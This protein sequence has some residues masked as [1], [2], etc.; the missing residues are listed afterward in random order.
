MRRWLIAIWRESRRIRFRFIFTRMRFSRNPASC[1]KR[2]EA[3]KDSAGRRSTEPRRRWNTLKSRGWAT[4]LQRFTSSLP[5]T[6]T[7]TTEPCSRS[8]CRKLWLPA[9]RSNSRCSSTTSWAKYL[10]ARDTRTTSSWEPSGSPR[11]GCGGR[12]HG[13]ATNFTP[14]R[15][16]LRISARSMCA[17]LCRRTRSS[18]LLGLKFLM[19]TIR[20]ARKP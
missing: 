1:R 13:I 5:M 16:S 17:W 3:S 10:R 19:W 8:S 20:M 14:I 9:N 6:E 4:W 18:E 15:N 2:D 7:R 12:A 11:W